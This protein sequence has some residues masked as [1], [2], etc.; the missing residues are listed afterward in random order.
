MWVNLA[1][2]GW[3]LRAKTFAFH[4]LIKLQNENNKYKMKIN[5]ATDK[6]SL[7][8]IQIK[9]FW[10]LW[11]LERSLASPCLISLK[12]IYLLIIQK[13]KRGKKRAKRRCFLEK[14]QNLIKKNIAFPTV[15]WT[16]T[17][18]HKPSWFGI[19]CLVSLFQVLSNIRAFKIGFA[20]PFWNLVRH[21]A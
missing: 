8:E 4:V 19:Y 15:F 12:V 21:K 10:H 16:K 3:S 11:R 9:W 7:T 14:T 18:S 6:V 13:K 1:I 5:L 20:L 17:Y 2:G